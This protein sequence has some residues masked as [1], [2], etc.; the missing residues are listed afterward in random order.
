M[1]F[2]WAVT[3]LCSQ[4]FSI[5]TT[6]SIGGPLH[7]YVKRPEPKFSWK[8]TSGQI[9]H[10]LGT[11]YSLRLT[12]QEWKGIVWQHNLQ[13]FVP[14]ELIYPS[15]ML[16]VVSGGSNSSQPDKEDMELGLKLANLS[17]SACAVLSQVPNQPLYDGKGEDDLIAHTFEKYLE[18]ED[19]TWLLLLPM[20]NSAIKAMD[21]LQTFINQTLQVTIKDFVIMGASKRGWTSWLTAA[22]DSRIK[23]TMPIVIDTLNMPDQM[24]YQLEVWGSYSEEIGDYT[25]RGIQDHLG[26]EMGQNLV[27]IVDPYSYRE[28]LT[29]PKLSV[30]GTNDNYWVLDAMN[31]YW[32]GLPDPKYVLYVPN[33]GHNL[34][35]RERAISGLTGFYRFVASDRDL[36]S[37]TWKHSQENDR[38]QLHYKSDQKPVEA[39]LW[40]AASINR[41]FRNATWLSVPAKLL[42]NGAFVGELILSPT[43]YVAILGELIFMI[44]GQ[45]CPLSTQV[46]IGTPLVQQ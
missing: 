13:V 16:L 7:D 41:D 24:K 29:M 15:T 36:P 30:I 33:S 37:I 31:L 32:D 27:S 25:V 42:D 28:Q 4:M 3:F 18:L 21:A 1:K 5:S 2:C 35:D 19:A 43:H 46:S 6:V 14:A 34:E 44:D 20:V 45:P 22:V 11:I 9:D 17:G 8:Q 23:A 39:R 12:S 38:L 10:N 26:T 40:V